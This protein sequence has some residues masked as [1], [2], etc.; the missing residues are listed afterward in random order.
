M[1]A[2]R[3]LCPLLLSCKKWSKTV[4]SRNVAQ[5]NIIMMWTVWV[6]L[7]FKNRFASCCWITLNQR[8][9]SASWEI[10]VKMDLSPRSDNGLINSSPISNMPPIIRVQRNC[11][12]RIAVPG[13]LR[14]DMEQINKKFWTCFILTV[15]DADGDD[16]RCR[17]ASSSRGECAE[18]CQAFPATLSDVSFNFTAQ[19]VLSLMCFS[20]CSDL[21]C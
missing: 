4:N 7:F 13:K 8:G 1:M 3:M 19:Q 18:V 21:Q 11:N 5:Q 17:W 12:G 2:T 9:G 14:Q 20:V 15:S 16:V 6:R 10:R